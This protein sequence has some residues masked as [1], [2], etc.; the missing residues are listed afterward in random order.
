MGRWLNLWLAAA[1]VGLASCTAATGGPAPAPAAEAA[2]RSIFVSVANPLAAQAGMN[3]LRRGGSAADAAIAVQAMLSLVEPQS[4]G[5]AGGGFMTFYDAR[6]RQ[7]VVY[8]GRETAPAAATPT[9]FVGANGEAL[10]FA[11]AV[12]SGRATGVPG[13]LRL[14]EMA[15]REHGRLQW[16]ELFG[17]AERTAREGFAVSPR[18]A[19]MVSGNFPQNASPDVRAY[20]RER[21]GTPVDV[22]D[23]LVNED[24]AAFLRRLA[25]EGPDAFYR[26][27]TAQRIVDR[28]R[29]GALPGTMTLADLAG[30]RAVK[31]D[32]VC[33]T[34]R[35][36][37]ACVPPPPSSGIA[38]LQL[39]AMLERTD[40]AGRN[41]AD[42]Q[43]WY[44]FAEAS[45]LMYADRDRYVG[46]PA[47]VQVPVA[48]LLDPAY[49]AG[50][51][52][53]IGERAGPPP[54]A[55]TPPGATAAAADRTLEPAG[56]THF[57]VGDAE[58]NVVSMTSTV[59]SIFGSGRMVDGM[60][61]NNQMTDFSFVPTDA[62]G[63][64]AAN[65]V[66]A[67]K[68]PRSSMAPMILMTGDRRFAGAVGSPGGNAILAYVGKALVGVI[69]WELPMA[70]A[71][72]LPNLIARGSSYAGEA[73]RFAPGVL[74]GLRARGIEV[75][76]GQ[77]EDSG[78]HGV[79]LRRGMLEGGADPRREGVFLVEPAPRR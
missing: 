4:S 57:V 28:V 23:P 27:A 53:L 58:G 61:L 14:L 56:T 10:P 38:L 45:R 33:R 64:P 62:A 77:G 8:D 2:P 68:R 69:D 3:V 7:V 43:G 59:E 78:L 16:R 46:D 32:P 30:Y 66:A 74:D 9:M 52:R 5:L 36:Y 73:P 15:H 71:I 76:P 20:F 42:P 11:Q 22:G 47:F 19:R 6:S 72:A 37:L 13:V 55:G 41:A 21:D 79:F 26:G 44:L 24:Y 18:L 65:A 39:L 34:Y 70:E 31:R 12:V 48:G 1:A 54:V 67:G 63:R 49:V 29:A 17:D 50:R 51:A 75:R 25:S 40:I 35:I 60:F